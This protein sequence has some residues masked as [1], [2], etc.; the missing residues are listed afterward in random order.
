MTSTVVDTVD[1]IK[2]V[3]FRVT[4]IDAEKRA[5]YDSE[6]LFG[7]SSFRTTA[8]GARMCPDHEQHG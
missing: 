1:L 2:I 3:D 5:L 7:C 8:S 4:Y 6:E